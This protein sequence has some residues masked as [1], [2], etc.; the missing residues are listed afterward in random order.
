VFVVV[1]AVDAEHL[2]E[3]TP[4]ENEHS[5]ETVRANRARPALGVGVRVRRLDWRADHLDAGK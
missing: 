5:V 4:A 2:L 3:V 1:A